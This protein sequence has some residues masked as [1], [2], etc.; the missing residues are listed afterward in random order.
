MRLAH[1]FRDARY[2]IENFADYGL[3]DPGPGF[4]WLRFGPDALLVNMQDG[5]VA[6]SAPDMFQEDSDA[7]DDGASGDPTLDAPGD[8]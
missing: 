4:E 2:I 8:Q 7:Q 6:G 3:S 5:D 1:V